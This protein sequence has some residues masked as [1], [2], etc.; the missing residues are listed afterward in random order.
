MNLKTFWADAF[1]KAWLVISSKS[2]YVNF[3]VDKFLKI[4][5]NNRAS[6]EQLKFKHLSTGV[7][8]EK[9]RKTAEDAECKN[10]EKRKGDKE[11]CD[12]TTANLEQN[13]NLLE[14]E[15][16]ESRGDE[17][18]LGTGESKCHLLE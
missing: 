14:R 17:K 7:Q 9:G 2:E 8:K 13:D 3:W 11:A 12:G 4:S 5:P 10:K 18:G 6:R 16:E 1:L 15:K